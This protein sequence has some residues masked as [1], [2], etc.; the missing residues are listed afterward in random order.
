MN[1]KSLFFACLLS[2]SLLFSCPEAKSSV[3]TISSLQNLSNE[4]EFIYVR[5]EVDGVIW[6]QV[7]DT[8]GNLINEYPEL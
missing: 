5:V 3:T 1:L 7:Y 4:E 8:K 2:L 6:I